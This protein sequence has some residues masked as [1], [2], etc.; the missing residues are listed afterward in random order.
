MGDIDVLESALAKESALVAAVR[1][2]QLGDPTPCPEYDVRA[3]L[4]H[5]VGWLRQFAAGANER[6]PSEDPTTYTTDDHAGAFTAAADDLVAGWR[7]GGV[8][9]N[10]TFASREM[11]GQ[12]VLGMTLM[13]YVTH[14]CD[15]AIATGQEVPFSDEELETALGHARRNLADDSRRGDFFGPAVPVADDAPLLERYLGFLGRQPQG[16]SA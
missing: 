11:P 9:R 5:V 2:E 6:T 15:L 10:V 1:P 14:G 16:A 3:L 13:E 7:S 12:V 4:D 8:D